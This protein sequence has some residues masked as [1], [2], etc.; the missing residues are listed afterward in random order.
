MYAHFKTCFS[1]IDLFIAI[2]KMII[3]R[4]IWFQSQPPPLPTPPPYQ[5]FIN[6]NVACLQSISRVSFIRP[7]IGQ[8]YGI[9]I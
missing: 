8:E 7:E 9:L 6:L 1:E 3:V 2:A 5:T 4:M